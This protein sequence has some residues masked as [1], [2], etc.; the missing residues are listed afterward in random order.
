M[1]I[2]AV[3]IAPSDVGTSLSK[4]VAAAEKP[5][6]DGRLSRPFLISLNP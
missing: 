1:P 5:C 4:Y 3:S 2:V 6:D